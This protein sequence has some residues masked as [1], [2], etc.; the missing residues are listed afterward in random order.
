MNVVSVA[1]TAGLLHEMVKVYVELALEAREQ[2][3]FLMQVSS[4]I[5]VEPFYVF[6]LRNVLNGLA[7]LLH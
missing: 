7:P 3:K 2:G 4:S 1:R 6:W 5:P